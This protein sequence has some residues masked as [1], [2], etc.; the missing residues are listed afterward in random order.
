MDQNDAKD[1]MQI[2]LEHYLK[3]HEIVL[4]KLIHAQKATE[5]SMD[6]LKE[7]SESGS[8]G[9]VDAMWSEIIEMFRDFGASEDELFNIEDLLGTVPSTIKKPY[10]E[11][12]EQDE[13]L[14]Q[15]KSELRSE[16]YQKAK[17]VVAKVQDE[18][19]PMSH[20]TADEYKDA[21]EDSSMVQAFKFTPQYNKKR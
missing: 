10:I 13:E 4:K 6:R 7:M 21:V 1:L 17:Q 3:H 16:E 18:P 20:M 19:N 14:Q 12:V 11:L 8:V 15:L 9:D 5:M 2:V